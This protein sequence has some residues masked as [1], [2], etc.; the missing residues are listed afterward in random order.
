MPEQTFTLTYLNEDDRAYGLAGM[1][2]SVAALNASELIA[3]VSLDTPETMVTFAHEYYFTGSPSISPK[4]TWQNTL[5]NFQVTS[6][7]AI[8]NVM[9]RSMVRMHTPVPDD[10]LQLLHSAIVD[11]GTGSVSLEEDE[12]ENIYNKIL[13]YNRRIFGNPRLHAPITSLASLI[14]RRRTLSGRELEEEL[15]R[16]Q[17]I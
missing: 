9:A 2:I 8:A 12:I 11:E 6:A 4:A 16:L 15:E 17:L 5:R 1:V 14:S 10:I 13:S 7:M 3:R